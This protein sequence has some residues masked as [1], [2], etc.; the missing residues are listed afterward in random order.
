MTFH[1]HAIVLPFVL[2]DFAT[3]ACNYS[4]THAHGFLKEKL[5][6]VPLPCTVEM[7]LSNKICMCSGG[8]YMKY[9]TA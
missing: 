3:S 1:T 8:K 5:N 7:E 2:P 4:Y 6:S 9:L